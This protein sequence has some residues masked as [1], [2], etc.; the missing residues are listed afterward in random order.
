M[1]ALLLFIAHRV[2]QRSRRAD[3]PC[4]PPRG[5]PQALG[6]KP[7]NE[8]I[9]AAGWTCAALLVVAGTCAALIIGLAANVRSGGAWGAFDASLAAG[10]SAHTSAAALRFFSRATH[11]GDSLALA[12]MAA[13][14]ACALWGTGKRLLATGWAVAL[15]G[16][17]LM[18]RGLKHLVER[19]RP[20]HLHGMAQADGFSFPS[21]HG[22]ASMAAYTLL[23]YLATRLL[24]PPWHLPLAMLAGA[25]IVTTGWSRVV[26]QVHYAS[27]VLAGWLL[28][29]AW[30]VCSVLAMEGVARWRRA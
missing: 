4:A 11:L 2:M 27:D 28:G 23:A 17:G 3:G 5:V 14:V 24:P 20:E 8:R 29:G 13:A 6:R 7:R 30:A 15:S 12:V 9:V 26:L 21:G 22:S 10:L 16:N 18:T 19:V 1:A 25:A